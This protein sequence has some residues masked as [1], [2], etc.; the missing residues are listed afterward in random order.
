ME[1]PE[2]EAKRKEAE[3]YANRIAGL[4]ELIFGSAYDG[5][6]LSAVAAMKRVLASKG[7]SPNDLATVVKNVNGEIAALKYSDDDAK[8]IYERGLAKGREEEARSR[9]A[10]DDPEEFYDE[11][12]QPR[13]NA[14]AM[15]CQKNHA[16]LRSPKEQEFVDDMAGSTMWQEP[17][18]RQAKWLLSIFIKLGGRRQ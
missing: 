14:M 17:T 4:V 16:Q 5:E 2:E 15:F 9:P 1:T 11:D 6:I 12:G 3:A 7:L 13:W 8:A 18:E 10:H